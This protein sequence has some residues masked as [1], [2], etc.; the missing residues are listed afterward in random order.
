MSV[1]SIQMIKTTPEPVLGFDFAIAD[2]NHN[3]KL[4]V[5][6]FVEQCYLSSQDG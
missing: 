6:C 2:Q 3:W 4:H 5:D 1:S